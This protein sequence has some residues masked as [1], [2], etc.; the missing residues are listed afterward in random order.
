MS[1]TSNEVIAD[2]SVEETGTTLK[3]SAEVAMA[4]TTDAPRRALDTP[5]GALSQAAARSPFDLIETTL[6]LGGSLEQVREMITLARDMETHDARKQFFAALARFKAKCPPIK[7]PKSAKIVNENKGTDYGYTWA[8]L[9]EIDKTVT[10]LLSAEDLS[11]TF[12][13]EQES[14]KLTTFCVVRHAAGHEQR[15]PVTLTV[16]GSPGMSEQ[17]KIAST[18]QN[19]RRFSLTSALG[20][21]TTDEIPDETG[22]GQKITEDQA[23]YIGDLI[24]ESRTPASRFLKYFKVDKAADILA[25]DYDSAVGILMD[26]KKKMGAK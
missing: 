1:E 14:N 23:T 9:E 21:S 11:Y 25:V 8:P 24:T 3:S 16:G 17:Q 6:R 26:N 15:T 4:R 22:G 13:H 10:P 12:E 5:A 7:K 19:G 20:L 18:M 2:A